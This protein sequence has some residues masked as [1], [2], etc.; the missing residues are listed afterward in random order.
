MKTKPKRI[1][2]IYYSILYQ[3]AWYIVSNKE[4][5]WFIKDKDPKLIQEMN[6][7]DKQK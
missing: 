4:F 5:H 1:K 7:L 2:K 6:I 3:D